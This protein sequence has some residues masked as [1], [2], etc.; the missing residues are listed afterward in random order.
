MQ[1]H[2]SHHF[3]LFFPFICWSWSKLLLNKEFSS[4]YVV[5]VGTFNQRYVMFL[6]LMGCQQNILNGQGLKDNTA[7]HA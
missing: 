3:K 4:I 7:A 2:V 5:E 6:L 1:N